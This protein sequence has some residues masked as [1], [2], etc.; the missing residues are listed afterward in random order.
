MEALR[1][2]RYYFQDLFFAKFPNVVAF[3]SLYSKTASVYQNRIG[4][5][6]H[7]KMLPKFSPDQ[8]PLLVTGIAGVAGYN[9]FK[10]FRSQYGD[11]VIGVRPK[12][13]WPLSGE[14]IIGCDV[15][16]QQ[17]FSAIVKQ[18][19]V[20]SILNCA[21]SCKLKGCE[22]D[23]QMANRVNVLGVRSLLDTIDGSNIQ[24]VHASIDLVYSGA[25][26]GGYVESD[27]TDP[28]T[29]YGRTMVEAEQLILAARPSSCILRISLP[30]GVSFN[31]HAGAIDWIQSRFAKG[32]P[33]TLYFDEVRTPTYVECLNEVI[34]EV[35]AKRI[36]GLFHAG[37]DMKWS[38]FQIAQIVNRVGGYD[39]ELLQGCPRIEAGPIPPRAGNVTMASAKLYEM[40]ERSPFAPWPRN[41]A[42]RPDSA[43]W[44]FERSGWRGSPELIRKA[45]YQR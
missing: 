24:L 26:Q 22:L 2:G 5:T 37:G 3:G 8:L 27:P 17:D 12:N 23:P 20:R 14:G 11:Q 41:E 40:L 34:E 21:G 4:W 10:Y 33:A 39:P 19:G 15:E 9:A 30:M 25:G 38:L 29:V 35:F 36:S 42:H 43:G 13:N 6:N 1:R 31:G 16:E 44:H 32:K 45:L 28:V 7:T 18:Y